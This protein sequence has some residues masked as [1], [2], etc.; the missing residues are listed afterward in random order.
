MDSIIRHATKEILQI[1]DDTPTAKIYSSTLHLCKGFGPNS[2]ELVYPKH[3]WFNVTQKSES[4]DSQQLSRFRF[5][6]QVLSDP[7]NVRKRRPVISYEQT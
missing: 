5:R 4:S 1:P 6:N 2:S 7:E 3:Q